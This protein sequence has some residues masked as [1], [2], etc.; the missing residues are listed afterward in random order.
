MGDPAKALQYLGEASDLAAA[1]HESLDTAAQQLAKTYGGSSRLLK[2]FGIGMG[3]AATG[4]GNTSRSVHDSAAAMAELADKIRGQADASTQTWSG[5]VEALKAHLEDF[6]A[7]IG[8]K[9][10]PAIGAIGSAM[11]GVGAVFQAAPAI[12]GLVSAAWDAL[13]AAEYAAMLPYVLIIAGLAAIGVAIYELVTHWS[14]IWG[15]IKEAA[16]AVWQWIVDHWP[17]LLGVLL[18]PFGLAVGIIIQYWDQIKE[19]AEDV[20]GAITATWDNFIGF[21]TGIPGRI[22]SAVG[23]MGKLL[24]GAGKDVIQGLIDGIAALLGSLPDV[25]GAIVKAVGDLSKLLYNAGRDVIQGLIDGVKSMAGAVGDAVKDAVGGLV[26]GAKH[27]LG[28]GSPS[29][30]FADIGHNV[31]LGFAQGINVTAPAPM[32]AIVNAV[33]R[34]TSAPY[35]AAPA[36][37]MRGAAGPAVHIENA[38]FATEVDVDLLM[39]RAAWAVQTRSA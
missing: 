36:P 4:A 34:M 33:D 10:G 1:K 29:T 31:M 8:A 23:D 9:Y 14:V 24:Y 35:A 26:G 11:A 3:T 19:A 12:I 38:T 13:T 7:G 20:I 32:G 16:A 2:E 39:R 28:I 5:H 6:V 27:L 25:P 37:M 17:L 21:L 15:A 30:L 18:G 22:L